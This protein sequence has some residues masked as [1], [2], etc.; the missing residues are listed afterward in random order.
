[1]TSRKDILHEFESVTDPTRSYPASG[2]VVN[3]TNSNVDDNTKN[4]NDIRIITKAMEKLVTDIKQLKEDNVIL[5][6]EIATLK[7]QHQAISDRLSDVSHSVGAD[8]QLHDWQKE[9]ANDQDVFET[10]I[11]NSELMRKMNDYD[12]RRRRAGMH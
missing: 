11:S 8:Q 6:R 2:A 7:T 5:K 9:D 1:M 4:T 3:V 12:E 10:P